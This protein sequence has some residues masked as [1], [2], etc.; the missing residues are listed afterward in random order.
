MIMTW[1]GMADPGSSEGVLHILFGV[2]LG[3]S[4][5]VVIVSGGKHPFENRLAKYSLDHSTEDIEVGIRGLRL[6]R[7]HIEAREYQ[8]ARDVLRL[9]SNWFYYHRHYLPTPVVDAW[10]L[11]RARVNRMLSLETRDTPEILREVEAMHQF[12]LKK[13]ADATAVLE[14]FLQE[15]AYAG[16]E[17]RT[18]S[19]P[20]ARNLSS[21]RS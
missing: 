20:S 6:L 10:L 7:K 9:H 16:Y 5:L 14:S 19:A 18:M 1:V 11:I 12:A 13:C 8:S 4:A 17:A 15:T 21:I 3:I 2:F